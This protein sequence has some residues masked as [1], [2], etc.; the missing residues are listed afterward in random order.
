MCTS[1]NFTMA[2]NSDFQANIYKTRLGAVFLAGFA[3]FGWK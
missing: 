3:V 1:G 2:E